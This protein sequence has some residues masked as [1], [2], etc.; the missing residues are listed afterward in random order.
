MTGG[1]IRRPDGNYARSASFFSE[2]EVAKNAAVSI[3]GVIDPVH[4]DHILEIERRD[5]FK[6]RDIYAKLVR[7]RAPLMESINTTDRA[8][9]MARRSRVKSILGKLV[10]TFGH[11]DP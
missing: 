8:E 11:G 7:V 10:F 2:R 9:K 5:V 1:V 6:T 4:H 3:H